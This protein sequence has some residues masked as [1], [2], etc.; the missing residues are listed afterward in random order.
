[1]STVRVLVRHRLFYIEEGGQNLKKNKVV[2]NLRI[3]YSA[4]EENIM[5]QYSPIT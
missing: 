1:M 5:T 2:P 3:F 4:T